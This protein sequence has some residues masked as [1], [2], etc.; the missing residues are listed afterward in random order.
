[1]CNLIKLVY[2]GK[3]L[4]ICLAAYNQK[5]N[6]KHYYKGGVHYTFYGLCKKRAMSTTMIIHLEPNVRTLV[7]H[8]V[9]W[10]SLMKSTWWLNM[11]LETKTDYLVHGLCR[12]YL[13]AW[14]NKHT[15]KRPVHTTWLASTQASTRLWCAMIYLH[16][17][18]Y[19]I[20][21]TKKLPVHRTISP[22]GKQKREKY[23]ATIVRIA[24]TDENSNWN[25]PKRKRI[26]D[27]TRE[28]VRYER[29][30][31]RGLPPDLRI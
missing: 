15:K 22:R 24:C 11:D 27:Y 19:A 14:W 6:S 9:V 10:N 5:S 26:H 2:I 17:E 21:L 18:T 8:C 7:I 13:I 28:I 3:Q 29:S 31:H 20:L 1:V 30:V 16:L 12:N 23:L 4:V 25:P